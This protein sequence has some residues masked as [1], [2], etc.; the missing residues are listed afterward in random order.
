MC[1]KIMCSVS[2]INK[3]GFSY[4]TCDDVGY[5]SEKMLFQVEDLEN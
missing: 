5:L 1:V 4:I 2:F 3:L